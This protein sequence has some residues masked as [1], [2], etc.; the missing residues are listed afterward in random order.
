MLFVPFVQPFSYMKLLEWLLLA[1]IKLLFALFFFFFFFISYFYYDYER[2]T[3][4][5]RFSLR[6][7]KSKQNR[8]FYNFNCTWTYVKSTKWWHLL[9]RCNCAFRKW[10][11]F[12]KM[13]FSLYVD[14]YLPFDVL[15]GSIH[16]AKMSRMLQT[17]ALFVLAHMFM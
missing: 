3:E 10:M 16:G 9:K 5:N 4:M 2:Q 17:S 7:K 15:H 6:K 8:S 11:L 13:G 1:I 14:L 12:P